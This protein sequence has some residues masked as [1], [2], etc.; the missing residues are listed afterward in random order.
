MVAVLL[1]PLLISILLIICLPQLILYR[2]IFFIQKRP[3]YKGKTFELLKF[4]TMKKVKDTDEISP[5]VFG[6]ILRKTGLDELPQIIN[7]LK[8][9]MSFVGPRPLLIDYLQ[10]YNSDHLKRH[11]VLPGITG[12]AQVNGDKISS[13]KEKFEFDL[14]YVNSIS[15]C[16]DLKIILSTIR[17]LFHKA[18]KKKEFI[19]GKFNGY[20]H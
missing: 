12:L 18:G 6:G 2:R 20:E 19:E 14:K 11:N 16:T 15:F 10:L 13:W 8:G 17:L 7:I 5:T 4:Q 1:I 9:D 3:G